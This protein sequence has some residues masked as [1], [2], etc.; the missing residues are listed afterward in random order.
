MVEHLSTMY[1]ALGSMPHEN[2]M[3]QAL[4]DCMSNWKTISGFLLIFLFPVYELLPAHI[5]APV[6]DCCPYKTN[7]RRVF[8]HLELEL[9]MVVRYQVGHWELN[10][11][12]LWQQPHVLNHW[13]ISPALCLFWDR[14]SV[15]NPVWSGTGNVDQ[16]DPILRDRRSACFY[17]SSAGLKGCST[18]SGSDIVI[19]RTKRLN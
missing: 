19:F 6:H 4:R 12:P 2:K 7:Q 10:P 1:K 3:L 14:L 17:L 13:G 8:D 9:E 15:F 16:A 18:T 5:C 11:G